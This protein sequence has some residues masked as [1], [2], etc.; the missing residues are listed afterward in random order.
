MGVWDFGFW[1]DFGRFWG[2]VGGSDFWWFLGVLVRFWVVFG[3]FFVVF[4]VT[5]YF[6][7]FWDRFAVGLRCLAGLG[8][9]LLFWVCVI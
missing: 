4:G 2:F 8:F 9:G 6:G 5:G 3:Y 7:R 1:G